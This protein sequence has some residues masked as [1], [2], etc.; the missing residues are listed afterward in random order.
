MPIQQKLLGLFARDPFY[1]HALALLVSGQNDILRIP[2][3]SDFTI[4]FE[5]DEL[6]LTD[7]MRADIETAID[8]PLVEGP[9]I[10]NLGTREILR[11][12]APLALKV[13]IEAALKQ[14]HTD[15]PPPT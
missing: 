15:S 4:P 8:A 12:A 13:E 14:F 7:S 9:A 5:G 2:P 11:L 10:G 3:M 1:A 6:L